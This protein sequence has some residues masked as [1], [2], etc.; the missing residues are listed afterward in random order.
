MSKLVSTKGFTLVEI[1]IVVIIIGI[2]AGLALPRLS[3][4]VE[5]QRSTEGTNILAAIRAAQERW[6]L[7][8]GNYTA[9]ILDLDIGVPGLNG[10]PF[11]RNFNAPVLQNGGGGGNC[12][13]NRLASIVR[14]GVLYTLEICGQG[15]PANIFCTDGTIPNICSKMGF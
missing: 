10:E 13:N 9:N 14:T 4:V 2:L 3:F 1:T 12:T 8:S 15:D 5:R 7:E 11:P 6:R